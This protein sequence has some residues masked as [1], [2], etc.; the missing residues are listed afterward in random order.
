M[1][2]N[3]M[4]CTPISCQR[5]QHETRSHAAP[6][7]VPLSAVPHPPVAS[8]LFL[9]HGLLDRCYDLSLGKVRSMNSPDIGFSCARFQGHDHE[10]IFLHD[11]HKFRL[12]FFFNGADPVVSRSSGSWLNSL[13]R[14]SFQSCFD[15]TEC[16][17][18]GHRSS[19]ASP[20]AI[21][22]I[23]IERMSVHELYRGGI[24]VVESPA[25]H[26]LTLLNGTVV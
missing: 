10:F 9:F 1:R 7:G 12:L 3:C 13:G 17:F 8:G 6:P 25:G 16:L 4:L 22:T 14:N 15:P 18:Y 2:V 19:V 11:D 24:N 26:N 20:F 5:N 21:Y 23:C